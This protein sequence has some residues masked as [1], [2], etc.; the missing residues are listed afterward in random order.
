VSQGARGERSERSASLHAVPQFASVRL[1]RHH[2]CRAV[3]V[4]AFGK[5]A[6]AILLEHVL[7]QELALVEAL[8]PPGCK[9]GPAGGRGGGMTYWAAEPQGTSR[10]AAG[11]GGAGWTAAWLAGAVTLA[12]EG[13]LTLSVYFLAGL[14]DEF[15]IAAGLGA[16]V[17]YFLAI[18]LLAVL[19][20]LSGLIGSVAVVLPVVQLSRWS[21][22]RARRAETFPW[23]LAA[24]GT[25]AVCIGVP[26]AL[27]SGGWIALLTA[28]VV[29]F[30][31][32]APAVLCA[33]AVT[34]RH[35][36]GARFK[37]TA[38]VFVVG[39]ALSGVVLVGGL[40]AYATGVLQV[41]EPP[42]LTDTQLVGIWADD[43][44]GTLDLR[45]DGTAI[46]DELGHTSD[47]CSG[48]GT[49]THAASPSNTPG[50]D[51]I[52]AGCSG[53]DWHFGGTEDE[54]TLY[55]WIGDPDSLNQYTL[56][57]R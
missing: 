11:V 56:R 2:H 12:A 1:L 10:S 37:L 23:S 46:A 57:R 5:D 33:R 51:A 48:S 27:L 16:Y 14:Q 44:G 47:G 18:V 24:C 28:L 39:L 19:L 50:L 4:R 52:I 53:S 55:Y 34:V 42:R 3:R 9:M 22:R 29:P 45:S 36:T 40:A 6:P 41:Y 38:I 15:Y 54:P 17:G 30:L 26:T 43:E 49:W 35:G 8:R 31:A 21:A 25:A 7:A 13:A 20:A 32:L